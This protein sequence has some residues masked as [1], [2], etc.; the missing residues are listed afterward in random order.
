MHSDAYSLFFCN[1][2]ENWAVN[3]NLVKMTVMARGHGLCWDFYHTFENVNKTS[4]IF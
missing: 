4:V 3:N 2:N 1:F